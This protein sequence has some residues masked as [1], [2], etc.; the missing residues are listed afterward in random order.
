MSRLL[1]E[2]TAGAAFFACCLLKKISFCAGEKWGAGA[3]PYR[4]GCGPIIDRR[5]VH[6]FSCSPTRH[7]VL[8]T[9][10]SF[11]LARSSTESVRWSSDPNG[12]FG[13][14]NDQQ[15]S[16]TASNSHWTFGSTFSFKRKGGKQAKERREQY[17]ITT[18]KWQYHW[19]FILL[20][21]L[22]KKVTKKSR[23]KQMLRCFCHARAQVTE[24]RV[25]LVIIVSPF[26]LKCFFTFPY[27]L[28]LN[29]TVDSWRNCGRCI[30]RLPF[31]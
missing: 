15:S 9:M 13:R 22:T 2:N 5:L 4:K 29:V 17:Y 19:H 28:Y 27:D 12:E 1:I 24:L 3:I 8:N 16:V 31:A 26:L 30:F 25:L 21:F 6:N 23:Q 20:F 7:R 11:R 10:T 14:G 18:K